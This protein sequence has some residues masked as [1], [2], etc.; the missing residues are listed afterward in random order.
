[1]LL[2]HIYRITHICRYCQVNVKPELWARTPFSL[3]GCVGKQRVKGAMG[4][5]ITETTE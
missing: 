1:M 4:E 5:E 3:L 2:V